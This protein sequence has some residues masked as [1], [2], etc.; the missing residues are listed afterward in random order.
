MEWIQFL[1]KNS[2]QDLQDY[3]DFFVHHFPEESDEIQS[4]FGG[5]F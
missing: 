5:T 2:R 3:K 1:V 4:A